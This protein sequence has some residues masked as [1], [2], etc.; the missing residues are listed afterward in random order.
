MTQG[1]YSEFSASMYDLKFVANS[2]SI[3]ASRLKIFQII[4]KYSELVQIR[5][6]FASNPLKSFGIGCK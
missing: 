6:R 4:A 1:I 5:F 2:S 3:V